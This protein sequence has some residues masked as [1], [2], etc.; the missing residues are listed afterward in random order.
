MT[1]L[2]EFDRGWLATLEK[3]PVAKAII[4][5]AGLTRIGERP[6]SLDRLT[7]IVGQSRD[8]TAT[9]LRNEFTVRIEGDSIY[10]DDPFPG[11]Q[12]RRMLYVGDREIPMRSGCAPDLF[13]Y[14]AVLDV[15]FHV[16]ENCPTTGVPIRVSFIPNGYTHVEPTET[17]TALLAVDDLRAVTGGTM[18]TINAQLCRYQPFFASAEAVAPWLDARPGSRV[19]TIKDMFERSWVTHYRDTIRPLIHN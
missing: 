13:V 12:V 3:T 8:A 10:W 7:A 4:G 6:A 18:D 17:V 19:F 1:S 16:E 15:P 14:A 2:E 9:L 5:L 11:D